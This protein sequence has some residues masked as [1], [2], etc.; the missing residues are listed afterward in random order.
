MAFSWKAFVDAL[1]NEDSEYYDKS[2]PFL[3]VLAPAIWLYVVWALMLGMLF[4]VGYMVGDKSPSTLESLVADLKNVEIDFAARRAALA[5]SGVTLAA[6]F[7]D[8]GR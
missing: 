7:S 4:A 5:F 3:T 1:K 2:F 8:R 6:H